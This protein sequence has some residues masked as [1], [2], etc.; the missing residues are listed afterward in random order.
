MHDEDTLTID[1]SVERREPEKDDP[2]A[3]YIRGAP[4]ASLGTHKPFAQSN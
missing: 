4:H 3:K 2:E 1:V